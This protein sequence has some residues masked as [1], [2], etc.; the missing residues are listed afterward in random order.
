M[1]V[2][3]EYVPSK[4]NLADLPSR[5]DFEMMK[6]VI[7]EATGIFPRLAQVQWHDCVVPDFS[8]WE[9]ALPVAGFK[10]KTRSGSRGRL[11]KRRVEEPVPS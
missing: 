8:T 6:R 4:Q 2:H 1:R 5:G 3:F 9:A 11:R 10:R 7:E